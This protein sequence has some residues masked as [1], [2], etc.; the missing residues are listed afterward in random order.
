MNTSFSNNCFIHSVEYMF[1]NWLDNF[2]NNI[3]TDILILTVIW[4]YL[5][6]NY[7]DLGLNIEKRGNFKEVN[8]CIECLLSQFLYRNQII[9]INCIKVSTN[10]ISAIL[11]FH[12]HTGRTKTCSPFAQTNSICRINIPTVLRLNCNKTSHRMFE[13]RMIMGWVLFTTGKHCEGTNI[14]QD[15]INFRMRYSWCRNRM[16]YSS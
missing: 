11:T 16:G 8:A 4:R 15:I 7:R 3:K 5:N 12:R 10:Q 13:G 6:P 14:L 2:P 9:Y 1:G